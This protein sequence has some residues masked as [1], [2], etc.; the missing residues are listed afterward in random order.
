M[1]AAVFILTL[2]AGGLTLIAAA[3][4]PFATVRAHLDRRAGDGSADPYTPQLHRRLQAASGLAGGVLLA[5]GGTAAYA[6]R[7][8]P[9]DLA[10]ERQRFIQDAQWLLK[11][12]RRMQ[13]RDVAAIVGLTLFAAALRWPYLDQQLERI[14]I[15]A[16][17]HAL[18]VADRP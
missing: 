9:R 2:V 15:V 3:F 10:R 6:M 14:E 5:L 8:P 17:Q 7:H 4:V 12:S 1:K 16:Q 13:R 11:S 18:H